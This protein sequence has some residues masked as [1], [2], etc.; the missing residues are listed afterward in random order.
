[1]KYGWDGFYAIETGA[2]DNSTLY[3]LFSRI[4]VAGIGAGILVGQ[5]KKF[6]G[7]IF[8]YI[9][10]EIEKMPTSQKWKHAMFEL[11]SAYDNLILN[12]NKFGSLEYNNTPIGTYGNYWLNEKKISFNFADSSELLAFESVKFYGLSFNSN[13]ALDLHFDFYVTAIG[14]KDLIPLFFDVDNCNLLKAELIKLG[15][16][17]QFKI[18]SPMWHPVL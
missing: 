2:Q 7:Y 11:Y 3:S 17:H 15:E 10:D 13:L 16:T 8:G 12:E 14:F 9:A 1:M 6:P 18:E 4:N 5:N